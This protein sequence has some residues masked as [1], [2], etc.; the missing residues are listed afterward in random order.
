VRA[1]EISSCDNRC[2]CTAAMRRPGIA[3][4]HAPHAD[5]GINARFDVLVA[6]THA[7]AAIVITT[8]A[9]ARIANR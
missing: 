7:A 9:F 2:V 4:H 6:A 1:S 3:A 5:Q 8:P